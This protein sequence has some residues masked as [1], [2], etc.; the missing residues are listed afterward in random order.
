M[1]NLTLRSFISGTL[2]ILVTLGVSSDQ[3]CAYLKNYSCSMENDFTEN[4][5]NILWNN[6]IPDCLCC[7]NFSFI[8][9]SNWSAGEHSLCSSFSFAFVLLV[10]LAIAEKSF[11]KVYPLCHCMLQHLAS[12]FLPCYKA[13]CD[14]FLFWCKFFTAYE[15]CVLCYR[16]TW[17]KNK[18][19][20]QNCKTARVLTFMNDFS[21]REKVDQ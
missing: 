6:D 15:K 4:Y 1:L 2:C 21:V 7:T 5:N 9:I 11:S 10:F 14:F 17:I 18:S 8:S 13:I 19:T 20:T 12:V 3:K 16:V